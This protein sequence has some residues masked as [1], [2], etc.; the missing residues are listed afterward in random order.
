ME[1]LAEE[2][3]PLRAFL[4]R[5]DSL[6]LV[7]SISEENLKRALLN[8]KTLNLSQCSF[9]LQCLFFSLGVA[10]RARLSSVSRLAALTGNRRTCKNATQLIVCVMLWNFP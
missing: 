10:Q 9:H 2:I 1:F 3:S 4:C 7:L 6:S 8:V 5:L